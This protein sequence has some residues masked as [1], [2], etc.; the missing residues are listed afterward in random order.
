MKA[1]LVH[2]NDIPFGSGME[3]GMIFNVVYERSVKAI[4][5]KRRRA[6]HFFSLLG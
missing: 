1:F 4:V 6:V 3:I 2:G 5:V